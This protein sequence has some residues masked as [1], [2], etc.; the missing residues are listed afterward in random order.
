MPVC[1]VTKIL[2]LYS[3]PWAAALGTLVLPEGTLWPDPPGNSC[4]HAP[5][6][7]ALL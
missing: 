3:G 6:A 1:D 4:N 5:K 2:T 7:Q